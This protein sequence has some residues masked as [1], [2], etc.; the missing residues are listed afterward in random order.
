MLDTTDLNHTLNTPLR[1]VSRDILMKLERLCSDKRNVK[2]QA[3]TGEDA[4]D[5]VSDVT[6]QQRPPDMSQHNISVTSS[7]HCNTHRRRLHKSSDVTHRN[8]RNAAGLEVKMSRDA[9]SR[10]TTS[11][12][13]RYTSFRV[14]DILRPSTS[15]AEREPGILY[16]VVT[17]IKPQ[18]TE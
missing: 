4:C 17:C 8:K 13:G 7:P 12:S 5:I 14:A 1:T 9:T 10:K 11:E 15:S 16:L 6:G 18:L 3:N 2:M